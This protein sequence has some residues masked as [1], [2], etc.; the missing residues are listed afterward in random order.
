MADKPLDV[1]KSFDA[2]EVIGIMTPGVVVALAL[3]VEWPAFRALLG[4]KG[5]S[6]GDFGLF[7]VVAFVLGHLI[8]A[9]GNF[10][11]P[12]IWFPCGLPTNWVRSPN[13]RLVT[14]E[15][16]AAFERAVSA[17]EGVTYD[18]A[19]LSRREWYS[20]TTRAYGRVWTAGRSNRIDGANRTYGLSRGLAA[21][22]LACLIW[23]AI[24]HQSAPQTLIGIGVALAA[25]VVRMRVSGVHYARALVLAFVDLS[26]IQVSDKLLHNP[27][28]EKLDN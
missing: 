10:I 7:V 22:L 8:Q 17:M 13:Q 18:F 6:V 12:I 26:A 9:L 1:A 3:A 11:E 14:P 24:A 16:R 2:Y 4:D 15:Q 21:A 25:A 19:K 28:L 5:L 23:H 20:I 27:T